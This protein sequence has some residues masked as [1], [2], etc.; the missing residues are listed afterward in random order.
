[1]AKG[2]L[3]AKEATVCT[4]ERKTHTRLWVNSMPDDLSWKSLALR[5]KLCMGVAE[6]PLP[7]LQRFRRQSYV[8]VSVKMPTHIVGLK[9]PGD[10]H[11]FRA[12]HLPNILSCAWFCHKGV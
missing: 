10:K 5:E 2:S 9:L 8:S 11:R 3:Q 6:P 1:M 4:G 12:R 7:R